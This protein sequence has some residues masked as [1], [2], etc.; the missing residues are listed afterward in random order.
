MHRVCS[1]RVVR[2]GAGCEVG[3][4]E[5]QGG[6]AAN[7]W[8]L[9]HRCQLKIVKKL[10]IFEVSSTGYFGNDLGYNCGL[11][12]WLAIR[13]KNAGIRTLLMLKP[14]DSQISSEMFF[15]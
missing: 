3:A 15:P 5:P 14:K 6:R 4:N 9:P 1:V 7:Q 10:T 2:L 12:H 13:A 11:S 8:V